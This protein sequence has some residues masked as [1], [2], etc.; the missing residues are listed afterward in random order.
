MPAQHRS[1]VYWLSGL[2]M[3]FT[4]A[5]WAQEAAEDGESTLATPRERSTPESIQFTPVGEEQ[6]GDTTIRGA[7]GPP[8]AGLVGPD[9]EVLVEPV[10]LSDDLRRA[11]NLER[12]QLERQWEQ[13]IG[14]IMDRPATPPQV[15][16]PGFQNRTYDPG[17]TTSTQVRE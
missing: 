4:G 14:P 7:L 15:Q 17:S 10:Y 9:T 5:L 2:M 8:S 1:H 12:S 13:L 3:A 11:L 6:L 16:Y